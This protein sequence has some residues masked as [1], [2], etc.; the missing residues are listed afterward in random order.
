MSGTE[1]DMEGPEKRK[2][3][4]FLRRKLC[5][6]QLS[7]QS[8][9]RGLKYMNAVLI[10][11]LGLIIAWAAW[12]TFKK[13]RKGGGCCGEHETTEKK[14]RVS[15]RNRAHYPYAVSLQIDGMTC[16]N[17]A[18]KTENALNRMEGTLAS[19]SIG[20][21]SAKVLCKSVPDEHA[22]REA[23]RRAGYIVTR[24]ETIHP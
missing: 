11:A 19:V 17:C 5:F 6:L 8:D 14:V 1:K 9:K 15:D 24:Y 20:D 2:G 16:E 7:L 12:T 4:S 3:M 10:S 21:H 18:R 13:V 22:I 23:V